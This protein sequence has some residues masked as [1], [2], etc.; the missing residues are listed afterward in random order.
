MMETAQ[1]P[2]AQAHTCPPDIELQTADTKQLER[3]VDETIEA[4]AET[5]TIELQV[6]EE[7]ETAVPVADETTG[8][9]EVANQLVEVEAAAFDEEGVLDLGD[10]DSFASASVADAFE[11][12]IDVEPVAS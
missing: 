4:P 5:E 3:I 8:E 6:V 11:L 9:S 7:S 12:E 1:A 2:V 10:I